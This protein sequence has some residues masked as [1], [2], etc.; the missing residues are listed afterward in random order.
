M[1]AELRSPHSHAMLTCAGDDVLR[2]AR[3]VRFLA[4]REECADERYQ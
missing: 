1:I 2:A 4:R 3:L